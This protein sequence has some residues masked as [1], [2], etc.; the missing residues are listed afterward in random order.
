[1]RH[2]ADALRSFDL[3]PEA[4][5]AVICGNGRASSSGAYAHQRQ[6]RKRE[7]FLEHGVLTRSVNWKPVIAAPQAM[8]WASRSGSW[9]ECDLIVAA[10][11]TKFQVTETSRGLGGAKAP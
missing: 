3:D 2:L 9:L 8:R 7:E 4:Q 10:A 6:L 5:V 11:G 1:V